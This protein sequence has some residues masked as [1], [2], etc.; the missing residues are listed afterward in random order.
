MTVRFQRSAISGLNLGI[1][2]DETRGHRSN[3]LNYVPTR[4]INEMRNRKCLGGSARFAYRAPVAPKLP[5]TGRSRAEPPQTV[6]SL[7]GRRDHFLDWVGL[8]VALRTNLPGRSG[9]TV[10][11]AAFSIR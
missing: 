10:R 4:Q 7:F 3:Q 2:K 5:K 1:E 8:G 6:A 11:P 9:V